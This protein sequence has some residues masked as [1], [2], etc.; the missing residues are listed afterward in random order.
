MAE[1]TDVET[2]EP[3]ST[4]TAMPVVFVTATPRFVSF[5]TNTPVAS[6]VPA[7]TNT[8]IVP[9][10]TALPAATATTVPTLTPMPTVFLPEV[11]IT[12]D[13]RTMSIVN[14][15]PDRIELLGVEFLVDGRMLPI[16]L[17]T[18]VVDVPLGRFPV[19]ACLQVWSWEE[20]VL[21]PKPANCDERWS[22]LM[23]APDDLF[24]TK[25][26]FD[27][28]QDGVRLTTCFAD[29]GICDVDLP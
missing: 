9:M 26:D 22:V 27:V 7:A 1:S 17:W 15:A 11:Q 29:A 5:V 24:W 14:V 25:G 21:L 13:D 4:P 3:T 28:Y 20:T 6:S 19:G 23:V 2:A 12:Y 10:E 16:T 18:Q 8:L